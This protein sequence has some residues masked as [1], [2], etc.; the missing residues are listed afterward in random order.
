M[1]LLQVALRPAIVTLGLPNLG[2]V[3]Y[4]LNMLRDLIGGRHI[5]VH[6]QYL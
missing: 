3:T 6:L 5:L 2:Y 4:V 1:S